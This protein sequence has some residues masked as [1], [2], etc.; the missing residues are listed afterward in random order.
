MNKNVLARIALI[1]AISFLLMFPLAK[2]QDVVMQRSQSQQEARAAIAESSAGAQR[3][4][5]PFLAVRYR[6]Y[7]T[8][9]EENKVGSMVSRVI[10]TTE[11]A[12]F[13][14]D[15][16][17][18]AASIPVEEKYKGLYKAL[19]FRVGGKIEASFTVPEELGLHKDKRRVQPLSARILIPVTD[20][21]GLRSTP[22]AS[23][24]KADISAVEAVQIASIGNTLAFA[25]PIPD[26]GQ[27][28]VF[29][30]TLDLIG[31]SALGFA[32]SGKSNK[33]SW[34]SPW[35]HPNFGG[36]FLP[37]ERSVDANGFSA[38]WTIPHLATKNHAYV[39]QIFANG[40]AQ[41]WDSLDLSFVELANLY[42]QAE[43]A[44]KYGMLFVVL[45][46]AGFFLYEVTIRLRI[47]PM[48]YLLVG[49]TLVIFFLLLI[50]ASEHIVFTQAYILAAVACTTLNTI[51]MA[52]VL[53]N[54]RRSLSFGAALSILYGVLY[55]ILAS[56]DNALIM[57]A[58][59]LFAMLALI[60]LAT[61]RVDW[62]ALAAGK[63]AQTASGD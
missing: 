10:E 45:T 9:T 56:E 54:W 33:V 13:A 41:T 39:S 52:H 57:G 4:A 12:I 19:Q 29:N 58:M 23:W 26:A 50:A 25:V 53:G 3:I 1:S 2:I 17:S 37:I 38:S 47:H 42:Q 7:D 30:A 51:Y 31:T 44:A 28:Y 16:L 49:L 34:Q 55:G 60:M 61:R 21:R 46:F 35:P 5:G 36:R 8:V 6:R 40:G 62:F 22:K 20:L 63:E 24:N 43:R 18:F 15:D 14:A 59:L 11:E 32:P 27:T 48:Q